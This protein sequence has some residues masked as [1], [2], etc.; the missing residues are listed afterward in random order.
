MLDL[1]TV[2]PKFT[3]PASRQQH[4]LIDICCPHPTLSANPP[5]A[6]AA[7]DRR[8]RQTHGRT[9]GR[10]MTLTAYYVDCVINVNN[11]TMKTNGVA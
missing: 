3:R 6:P 4:L 10:F 11:E 5:A 7:V 9:L 1:P 8:D 2:G